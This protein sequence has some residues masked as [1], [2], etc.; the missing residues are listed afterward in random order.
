MLILILLF[1]MNKGV[2]FEVMYKVECVNVDF[3]CEC[4]CLWLELM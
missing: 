2:L 1:N 3:D 4:I